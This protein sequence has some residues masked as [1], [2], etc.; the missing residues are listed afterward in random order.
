MHAI[1][2]GGGI[3][4][5]AAAHRLLGAGVRVT[6]VEETPRWGGKLRSGRIAGV[7]TDLGAES[8]LARRPEA[9]ELARSVGLGGELRPPA[10][11]GAAVWTRGALRPMPGGHVMGV[12]G[13][14]AALA[15]VLSDAG[16]ARIAKDADLPATD[17][18][19]D[20]SVGDYVAQRMGSEVVDRLVEPLLGGVYAGDAYRISL[21][22]ALPDLY[23]AAR[24]EPSLLAAVARLR[25]RTAHVPGTPVFTGL[26]GGIGTLPQ[27]VAQACRAA[28]GTLLTGHAATAVRRTPQGWAVTLADGATL[29]GTAVV[30]AVPAAPAARLLAAEAP[31]AARELDAVEYASM[32]LVTLAFRRADLARLP[33][34]SGF[35]VPAVDGRGIKAAT[36]SSSKW[37]WVATQDPELF[38]MRASLGRYGEEKVLRREDRELVSVA[39]GDLQEA[40]GLSARPV[41][42]LVTRWEAGLPQYAVGHL[43]RVRRIR[44]ALAARPGLMVCGAAYDGVGI[45][46]CIASGHQAALELLRTGD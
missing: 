45:P 41:Q 9:I 46:A 19:E 4:G 2:I 27:A 7:A 1:V 20:V 12:P 21:R 35:L 25:E 10:V 38:V 8:L 13:T 3:S 5:L 14:A 42:T 36:F 11:A 34:G 24:A 44:A 6:V 30:V 40:L 26:R 15:G 17:P 23:D 32:A 28:G 37:D 16:L 33:R 18:G 22:A 31:A 39:L 29:T 43:G